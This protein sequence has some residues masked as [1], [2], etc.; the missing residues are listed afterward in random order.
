MLKEKKMCYPYR[1]K[2]LSNFS[3]SLSDITKYLSFRPNIVE[4]KSFISPEP[5]FFVLSSDEDYTKN[6]YLKKI[7]DFLE[8]FFYLMKDFRK[9][10]MM[11]YGKQFY[12][13]I[14]KDYYD[15]YTDSYIDDCIN[16]AKVNFYKNFSSYDL[17]DISKYKNFIKKTYAL[18]DDK[19]INIYLDYESVSVNIKYKKNE[20]KIEQY[21]EDLEDVVIT[22]INRKQS[23]ISVCSYNNLQLYM[24]EY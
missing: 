20:F 10:K 13:G 19:N 7:N 14:C 1:S 3:N 22:C 11:E 21:F 5:F 23:A 16:K 24:D 9:E 15:I 2:S 12:L 4:T 6:S 17:P 8:Y 18:S